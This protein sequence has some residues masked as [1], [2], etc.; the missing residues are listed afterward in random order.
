MSVQLSSQRGSVSIAPQSTVG[1]AVTVDLGVVRCQIACAI[2][3]PL[4]GHVERVLADVSVLV[5][6]ALVG[7][8]ELLEDALALVEE[9][10]LEILQLLLWHRLALRRRILCRVRCHFIESE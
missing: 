3:G 5:L 10:L 6:H 1:F 2:V 7:A 4:V 9:P 8:A